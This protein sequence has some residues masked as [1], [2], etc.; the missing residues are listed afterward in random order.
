MK[1]F[2][3][4][5]ETKLL[6]TLL[7]PDNLVQFNCF[8]HVHI[9]VHFAESGRVQCSVL[10]VPRRDL[11]LAEH[12]FKSVHKIVQWVFRRNYR[13]AIVCTRVEIVQRVIWVSFSS[14]RLA[15]D[16]VRSCSFKYF[17][18]TCFGSINWCF[19]LHSIPLFRSCN[20]VI[21]VREEVLEHNGIYIGSKK[22]LH[23]IFVSY[24]RIE[25]RLHNGTYANCN[26]I[27]M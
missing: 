20:G 23:W 26:L 12:L 16:H 6:H 5:F 17:G 14:V 22:M 15:Y 2:S 3:Q 1:T 8:V 19:F 4:I 13:L 11:H 21:I 7:G 24:V 10:F 25:K 18:S 9:N 27:C